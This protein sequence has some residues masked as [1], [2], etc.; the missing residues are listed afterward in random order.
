M[1]YFIVIWAGTVGGMPVYDYHS[2]SNSYPTKEECMTA[3]KLSVAPELLDRQT[4]GYTLYDLSCSMETD[5]ITY[6][7]GVTVGFGEHL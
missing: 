1:W 4:A 6:D 3:A 2:N 7:I 5:P